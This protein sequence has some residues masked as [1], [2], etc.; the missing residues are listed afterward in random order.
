LHDVR[1]ERVERRAVELSS[2]TRRSE[3]A[4][5]ERE[6]AEQALRA[7]ERALADVA[8]SERMRLEHGVQRAADLQAELQFARGAARRISERSAIELSARDREQRESA[9]ESRARAVLAQ[10]DADSRAVEKHR[11]RWQR[12]VAA[13]E[14]RDAD[15]DAL[16]HFNSRAVGP[17]GSTRDR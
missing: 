6:R 10:A 16:D 1:Q 8:E 14:E 2:Q 11:E 4:T 9:A 13:A 12:A 5:R 17:R 7:E 15:D 3:L